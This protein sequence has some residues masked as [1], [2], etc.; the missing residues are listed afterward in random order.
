MLTVILVLSECPFLSA[1]IR[2]GYSKERSE[3]SGHLLIA[4]C[5]TWSLYST[6]C[7]SSVDVLW[8]WGATQISRL[9]RHSRSSNLLNK[10]DLLFGI[11]IW[12]SIDVLGDKVR[13]ERIDDGSGKVSFLFNYTWSSGISFFLGSPSLCCFCNLHFPTLSLVSFYHDEYLLYTN[14]CYLSISV[15]VFSQE[16][17]LFQ[18]F[19]QKTRH[20]SKCNR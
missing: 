10:S 3:V 5:A 6:Y 7:N 16:L 19:V 12:A 1:I 18:A 14:V 2:M 9:P 20:L 17:S 4:V 11:L 8:P 13:I 15:S